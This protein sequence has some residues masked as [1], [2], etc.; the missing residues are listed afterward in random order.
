[1]HQHQKPA[2]VVAV[3]LQTLGERL[4]ALEFQRDRSARSEQVGRMGSGGPPP[5]RQRLVAAGPRFLR[6]EGENA[7]RL[8]PPVDQHAHGVAVNRPVHRNVQR[9][10]EHPT[11]P[12][13]AATDTAGP[14]ALGPASECNPIEA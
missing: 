13:V 12:P 6:V 1:V 2:E 3:T 5:G 8:R 11:P 4:V 7:Q 10:S 14:F 9:G